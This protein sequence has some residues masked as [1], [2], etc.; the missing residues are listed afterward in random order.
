MIDPKKL[1]KFKT[2]KRLLLSSS[3]KNFCWKHAWEMNAVN[4]TLPDEEYAE[5]Y[6]QYKLIGLSH[7][8]YARFNKYSD[9]TGEGPGAHVTIIMPKG[10]RH[11]CWID[12]KDLLLPS[13][14]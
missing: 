13:K 7:Y 3:F 5:D 10:I 14:K 12:A 6:L 2:G 1:K 4:N 11:S 8:A 9:D